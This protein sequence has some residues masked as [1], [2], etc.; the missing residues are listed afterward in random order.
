VW[1]F[2]SVTRLEATAATRV[3]GQIKAL[4]DAGWALWTN[5]QDLSERQRGAVGLNRED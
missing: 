1:G 3:R 5:P 2:V 4:K